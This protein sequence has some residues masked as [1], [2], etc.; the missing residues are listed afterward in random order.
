MA[1]F[2]RNSIDGETFRWA[3]V[4]WEVWWK[5]RSSGFWGIET[6]LV[7]SLCSECAADEVSIFV[8]FHSGA[9]KVGYGLK[10][11]WIH[12]YAPDF[13]HS[14]RCHC[15]DRQRRSDGNSWTPLYAMSE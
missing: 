5:N 1:D 9:S 6:T 14:Q 3:C 10:D 8:G 2:D 12:N 13:A 4:S 11:G 7:A 15:L